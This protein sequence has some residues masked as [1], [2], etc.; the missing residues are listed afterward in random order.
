MSAK[1]SALKTKIELVKKGERL[2]LMD[3]LS[4]L[5]KNQPTLHYDSLVANTIAYALVL[6]SLNLAANNTADLIY[7][8]NSIVRK[9]KEALRLFKDFLGKTINVKS[10]RALARL[11]LN[12]A[13]SYFFNDKPQEALSTYEISKSFALKAKDIRILGFVNLYGGEVHESLG[14]FTEASQNYKKANTHFIK[15]KDT[16]NI[17]NSKNALAILYSKNGFYTEAKQER[18]ETIT[19]AKKSNGN[20]YLV[21]LYA[22]AAED[23]RRTGNIKEGILNLLKAIEINQTIEQ[24]DYLRP[25]LVCKIIIAYAEDNRIDKAKEY[26]KEIENNIELYTKKGNK[27]NYL[28]A[29]KNI[30]FAKGNYQKSLQIAK[31]HLELERK[32]GKHEETLIAE[33]FLSKVYKALGDKTNAYYHLNNYY[34]LKDSI[35]SV[36]KVKALAYYQTLYE[37]EKRD[38]KIIEQNESINLLDAQNKLKKQW[39][40]FTSVGLLSFFVFILLLKSRNTAKRNRKSE[41]I[42]AQNLIKALEK[43]RV[44]LARELHDGVG[45]KLMLL[46]KKTK[47]FKDLDLISL[48]ESTLD[49]L[50]TISQAIHPPAIESLGLTAALEAMING[51]DK[52]TAVF[53]T[54]DIDNIDN[55]ISEECELHLYR[56]VQEV[57]NNIVKHANAKATYITIKKNE[58]L[59]NI[60]IEDNG[61]GFDFVKELSK[62]VS[63]GMKT[64]QERSKIIKS[65]LEITTQLNKGT[66]IKLIIPL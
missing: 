30:Y 28:E 9:P 6:D 36:Q 12:G 29:I 26:I 56:I 57:L 53:F 37:T 52:H 49:E 7:Y 47:M 5:V 42:Y 33:K 19:L 2:K 4:N 54:N 59:I 22:N 43:E 1:I 39:L 46:T 23:Y 38:L 40:I 31:E 44:R 18:E 35:Y 61:N 13:D 21:S 17:I 27:G 65:N 64:L 34:E 48:S 51:V 62:N 10:N 41:E 8:Y 63:L 11:Y 58:K 24:G 15:V 20:R 3:S 14:N 16:S 25:I 55:V 60:T 45:Q 50:R 66:I 32:N